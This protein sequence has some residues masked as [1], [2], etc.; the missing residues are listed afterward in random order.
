MPCV[1][2]VPWRLV[3]ERRRQRQKPR[4]ILDDAFNPLQPRRHVL[5]RGF[6]GGSLKPSVLC[7]PENAEPALRTFSRNR[8]APHQ[9]SIELGFATLMATSVNTTATAPKYQSGGHP[10]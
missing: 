6:Q 9:F 4:Q 3:K 5:S 7:L 8:G 2:K 1:A 10:G